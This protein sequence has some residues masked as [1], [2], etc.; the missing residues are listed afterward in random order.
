M[1]ESQHERKFAL[2]A[3]NTVRDQLNNLEV[4][5]LNLEDVRTELIKKSRL[6]SEDLLKAQIRLNQAMQ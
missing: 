1:K 3:F 5:L 6:L 4:N 2:K